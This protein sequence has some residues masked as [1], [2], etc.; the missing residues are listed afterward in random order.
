[1]TAPARQ[2]DTSPLAKTLPHN[3]DA[4]RSILG[5][6][7][8][9]GLSDAMHAAHAVAQAA[10]ILHSG[11]FFDAR[12]ERLFRRMI[13][14]VS[15]AKPIDTVTLLDD[16]QST[17]ELEE[18]G[19]AI[20]LS[21][22]TD[23]MPNVTNIEQYAHI[24]LKK[25]RLR[26]AIHVAE[27]IQTLAFDDKADPEDV[28]SGLSD[29]VKNL[30]SGPQGRPAHL[31]ANGHLAYP[32]VDFMA[33]QFPLPEQLVEVLNDKGEVIGGLIPA[34]GT[35]MIFSMP[36]HLKSYFTT[37]LA[38]ACTTEGRKLGRLQ[39]KK[40]VRTMLVQMEDPPGELQWRI[41][42]LTNPNDFDSSNFYVIPRWDHKGNRIEV[43]FPNEETVRMMRSEIEHFKPTLVIF[44]VV[45][46][47]T[48]ADLNSPKESASFLEDIDKLREAPSNPTM[49][50]VHHENRKEADIMYAAANSYNLPGWAQVMVQFKRKRAEENGSSSVE[51]EVDHKLAQNPEPMSM[52]LDLKSETPVRLQSIE[53]STG[54]EDLRA[55]LGSQW[56]ERDCA[57]VMGVHR[58]T[59]CRRIR[60]YISKGLVEKV[61]TG[62]RGRSGG[63]AVYRFIGE[64]E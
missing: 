62:K 43:K 45:R 18:A 11:D 58:A 9:A 8:V 27:R 60:Q 13:G 51:M 15:A 37:A 63:L 29:T 19:G 61:V 55:R 28:L 17:G 22:L 20:Y 47:M 2:R 24:V 10:E 32:Y 52:I 6:I 30:G 3:P 4:E 7:L 21:T 39:V 49:V 38:L 54:L 34:G 16:L 1:M 40:P 59:A 36:H 46:R 26:Q 48:N 44:D 5:A 53:D 42:K 14:M 25:S 41:Q 33:A 23:G 56:T 35:V 31:G 50:L 12:H 57:D 64:G